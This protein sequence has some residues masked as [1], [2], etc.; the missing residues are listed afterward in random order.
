M[1]V[2][3]ILQTSLQFQFEFLSKDLIF[4]FSLG[5]VFFFILQKVFYATYVVIVLPYLVITG[6]CVNVFV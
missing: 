2:F 3:E 1:P 4:L 5:F 6:V